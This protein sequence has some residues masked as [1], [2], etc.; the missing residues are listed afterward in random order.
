[1]TRDDIL[2]A[3]IAA[4]P[5][6]ALRAFDQHE[7]HTRMARAQASF[8]NLKKDNRVKVKNKAGQ[9]TYSF[10]FAP[11]EDYL[12]MARA[13]YAAEGLCFA[14]HVDGTVPARDPL[15]TVTSS[16]SFGTATVSSSMSVV[17]QGSDQDHG[18]TITYLRRYTLSALMATTG[19]DEDDD[20]N[21][22]KTGPRVESDK[23]AERERADKLR[24]EALA[25]PKVHERQ[26]AE[27]PAALWPQV[28]YPPD[29]PEEKQ[30]IRHIG[31]RVMRILGADFCSRPAPDTVDR[32]ADQ[33][34]WTMIEHLTQKPQSRA[35]VE[36]FCSKVERAA[37]S[38]TGMTKLKD[39]ASTVLDVPF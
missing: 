14:Q 10:V 18:G 1:M 26:A 11:L 7:L 29:M 33:V 35:E 36:D 15:I 32:L 20:A 3:L 22:P 6:A 2:T 34:G 4:D 23:P 27:A 38:D 37:K 16:V 21:H 30:G 13:G 9:D 19:T 28:F 31:E 8:R 5:G 17:S 39:R 24:A 12:N 25:K